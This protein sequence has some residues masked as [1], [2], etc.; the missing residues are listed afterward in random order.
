MAEFGRFGILADGRPIRLAGGAFDVLMALI[1]ASGAVISEDEL[2]S[3]VWQDR[4]VDQD[5]QPATRL[6]RRAKDLAPTAS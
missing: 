3:R 6:P 1:E 2:L 4:I 5:R